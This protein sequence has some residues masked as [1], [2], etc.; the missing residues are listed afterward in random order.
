MTMMREWGQSGSGFRV[1]GSGLLVLGSAFL[2]SGFEDAMKMWRRMGSTGTSSPA[3]RPIARACGPAALTTARVSIVPRVV[4]TAATRPESTRSDTTS[5]SRSIAAPA[6]C[7]APCR[8]RREQ[9][10][11]LDEHDV[12]DAP[13]RQMIGDARAHTSAADDD[14]VGGALHVCAGGGAEPAG[15]QPQRHRDTE[16]LGFDAARSADRRFL[17]G[18]CVLCD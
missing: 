5:V 4:S 2:G 16:R 3:I 10:L 13:P 15:L 6:A 11:A 7:A 18:L 17:C 12:R 14:D 1:P 8:S 9:L